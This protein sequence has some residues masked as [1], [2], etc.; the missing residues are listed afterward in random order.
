MSEHIAARTDTTS[1]ANND[2]DWVDVELWVEEV[3]LVPQRGQAV[4][5]APSDTSRVAL[6]AAYGAWPARVAV[7]AAWRTAA[8]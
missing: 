1:V 8:F 3:V 6:L 4:L 7:A 5:Q 2:D